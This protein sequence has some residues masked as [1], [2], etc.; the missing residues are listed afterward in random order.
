TDETFLNFDGISYGKGAAVL[1]QLVKTMGEDGFKEG[2]RVYFRRHRLGNA[3]LADLLAALQGASE[4]DLVHWAARWLKTAGVNTIGAE[5]QADGARLETLSLTQTAPDTNPVLRPHRLEVALI[6]A[7]GALRVVPG[8]IE[9]AVSPVADTADTVAPVFVYPNHGDHAYAKVRL[10]EVSI[11]WARRSLP[12]IDDTLL[13]QQVW[14]SLWEMVRDAELAST[15]YLDLVRR[16][17]PGERNLTIVQ[18][19]G[20]TVAGAIAR[21]VPEDL[22]D[23]ERSRFVAEARKAIDSAPAGDLKVMWA[24]ALISEAR[25]AADVRLAAGL[26][27]VPPDGLAIDQDMRWIVSVR[28]AEFAME[29]TAERLDSERRRD[30]SDRG[31]RAI[32]RAEAVTPDAQTKDEIWERL[33]GSGYGSL[34]MGMAAAGGFWRRSQRDMLESFVPRFF[35]GLPNVFSEWEP[36]AARSYYTTFFPTYRIDEDTRARVGALLA[37]GD[38]GSMLV[39]KLTETADDLDR[40]LRSRAFATPEPI[41]EP[42]TEPDDP[43]T[44]GPTDS[45]ADD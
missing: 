7:T 37:R 9:K 20:A 39:R 32:Q 29:G 8:T 4:V 31:D 45:P 44:P 41:P 35:D 23:S 30:P 6:D 22:I 1:K 12:S 34:H 38:L 43:V 10:D 11:A 18:M 25:S 5:W 36:E 42:G 16:H 13:R 28:W 27:D 40:A 33:H 17:L 15:D 24:R 14:A 19:V 3:T 2:M 21:Y 26:V